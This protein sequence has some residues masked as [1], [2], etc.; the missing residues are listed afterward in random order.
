MPSP[1][2]DREEHERVNTTVRKPRCLKLGSGLQFLEYV[3]HDNKLQRG[4]RYM[5]VER[6]E[7]AIHYLNHYSIYKRTLHSANIQFKAKPRRI[8]N[9]NTSLGYIWDIRRRFFFQ[10]RCRAE[11]PMQ[12]CI[13]QATPHPYRHCNRPNPRKGSTTGPLY[14]KCFPLLLLGYMQLLASPY[15]SNLET[16]RLTLIINQKLMQR[17]PR[18]HHRQYRNLLISNHFQQRRA[19]AIDEPL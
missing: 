13:S 16:S 15:F 19:L 3:Y 4:G 6:I 2:S 11:R 17:L 14:S 1:V 18:R 12:R 9:Q 8:R 7:H 5:Y 10:A